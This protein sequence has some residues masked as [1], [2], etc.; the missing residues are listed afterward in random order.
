MSEIIQL[1][2]CTDWFYLEWDQHT[3]EWSVRPVAAWGLT[4]EGDA[5]GMLPIDGIRDSARPE[6]PHLKPAPDSGGKFVHISMLSAKQLTA[7]RSRPY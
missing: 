7:A 2:P 6:Y 5:L 4:N 1:T 3:S